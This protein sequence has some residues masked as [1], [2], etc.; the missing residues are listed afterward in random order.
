[1]LRITPGMPLTLWC[2][3]N[4]TD[5]KYFAKNAKTA[6][7]CFVRDDLADILAVDQA[8][9][10]RIV[11]AETWKKETGTVWKGGQGL[12][13]V[14]THTSKSVVL[15]VYLLDLPKRGLQVVMRCNFHDWKLS[16]ISE[17][18]VTPQ[19]QRTFTEREPINSVYCEGFN[20]EWVFGTYVSN[21]RQ[22]T[23]ELYDRAQVWTL[24]WELCGRRYPALDKARRRQGMKTSEELNGE[25]IPE[26]AF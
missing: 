15:P 23:I 13:V 8:D 5:E 24:F 21:P 18:P 6:Q 19:I 1:M 12:T 25:E 17:A 11:G 16:F 14:A 9:H 22:F 26:E 7:I 2:R 4:P 20:P 3:E 10:E